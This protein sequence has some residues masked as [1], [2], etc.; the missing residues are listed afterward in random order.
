M[1]FSVAM[2]MAASISFY[3]AMAM[4]LVPSPM[5]LICSVKASMRVSPSFAFF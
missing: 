3:A 1:P 2:G 5:A 4:E